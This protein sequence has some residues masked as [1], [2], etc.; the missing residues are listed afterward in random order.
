MLLHQLEGKRVGICVS[1]GLDS[2]TVAT[3]LR[4]AGVECVCF[5][6]DLAQPD[7]DDIEGVLDKMRP[8]GVETIIVDLKHDMADACFRMI[9]TQAMYDGGY[10]NTTGIA[11]AVTVHGLLGP[12]RERGCTVLAH[13]ATGRGNDQLRFERYTNVLAPDMEVYAPWRDP[14]LLDQF[15]GRKQ[16]IEF[17]AEHDIEVDLGPRK[18]YS[19]DANLA[20]LSHEAEDLEDL[21][22]PMS[23]VEPLMCAWPQTAP[24][25]VETVTLRYDR[26]NCVAI[27]G[28]ELDRLQCMYK[29]NEIGGRNGVGLR[30][31]LENRIIGTKSRGVYEA[32][33]LELLGTG[34]RAVYQAVMDRRS[35]QL[36]HTMSQNY[37]QQ[38]YDGRLYDPQARA[39][40]AA[41]DVLAEYATATVELGLYKGNILFRALRD[42]PHSLYNP[43]D[44]S[45]EASDGLN[46]VSSQGFV[47]VQ[48]VEAIALARAGQIVD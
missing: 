20:G 3:R 48:Q 40:L 18:R 7:E 34:L 19:T 45:M 24:D 5:T 10:W 28:V 31:A 15:P 13:G 6:A 25:E 14:A 29:A 32:P 12:M 37:A 41:V 38:I 17:L 11:R 26:G 23:I 33:G 21:G 16:M 27:N 42:C 8:T 35:T 1:G 2:K 43:A 39:I 22:T 4:Q 9:R 36:F 30:N 44:A 47:E 46:P